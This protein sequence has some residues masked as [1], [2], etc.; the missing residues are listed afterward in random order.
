MQINEKKVRNKFLC[1][2]ATTIPDHPISIS[3]N[4]AQLEN[5]Y[6]PQIEFIQNLRNKKNLKLENGMG[7]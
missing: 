3:G 5:I 2:G 4:I 7:N 1:Y 6:R